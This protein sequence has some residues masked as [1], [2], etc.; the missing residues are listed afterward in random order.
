M[1]STSW[2]LVEPLPRVPPGARTTDTS[3]HEGQHSVNARGAV[4]EYERGV[5]E[6]RGEMMERR[7][8]RRR[9]GRERIECLCSTGHRCVAVLQDVPRILPSPLLCFK[10]TSRTHSK[11]FVPQAHGRTS[12]VGVNATS[13]VCFWPSLPATKLGGDPHKQLLLLRGD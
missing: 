3:R 4:L 13:L 2:F 10:K 6:Q 8:E 1:P 7:V 12:Q 9:Y 11:W 5:H